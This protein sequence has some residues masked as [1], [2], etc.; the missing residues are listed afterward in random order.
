[1]RWQTLDALDGKQARRTGSSSPL[2][3]LFDHGV[4]ARCVRGAGRG[5]RGLRAGC[6]AIATVLSSIMLSVCL[7]L[8]S[9][10]LSV[11]LLLG[12]ML[13]FFFANWEE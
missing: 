8:G 9:S 12:L 11:I 7:R 2:G 4:R 3:Q 1:M 5:P 10:W 6:D 13:P